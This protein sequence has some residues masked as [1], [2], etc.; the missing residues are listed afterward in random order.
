[1]IDV[2][3]TGYPKSGNTWVTRLVA[4]LID[5][6]V[7]GFWN[8]RKAE[9]AREGIGR[10]SR[11]RCFKA[12]QT[13]A[14]LRA[15]AVAARQI[16]YVVRDPRDIV[17]SGARY[18]H[19]YRLRIL[20]KLF[21]KTSRSWRNSRRVLEPIL[22]SEGYREARMVD[23]LLS[24]GRRAGR[25]L[26]LPWAQHVL[27]CLDA[28]QFFVRYEDLLLNPGEACGRMLDHLG[29]CRTKAQIDAAIERQSF[30]RKREAFIAAGDMRQAEFL[31]SGM[32]EQWRTALSTDHVRRIETALG[33]ELRWFGYPVDDGAAAS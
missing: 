8:S 27:P 22:T 1:V 30:A 17:L 11:H 18:F 15:E 20:E 16:I 26:S 29:L 21:T 4:E 32:A 31:R 24:G 6:P 3:I 28:G 19:F 12:H 5:C 9:I 25:F 33:R 13:V 10:T 23:V 14:A 7:V 2:V